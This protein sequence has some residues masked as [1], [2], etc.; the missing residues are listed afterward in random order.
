MRATWPVHH[1]LLDLITRIIFG[2]EYRSLSSSY[3]VFSIP[4][5]TSSILGLNIPQSTLFSNA[6]H[7]RTSLN[8][9]DQVSNPYK[10]TQ[11][12]TV[13]YITVRDSVLK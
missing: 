6:L 2:E 5:V 11:K 13:L 9:S 8:V 3:V 10:T 12:I 4:L 7:L 1:I